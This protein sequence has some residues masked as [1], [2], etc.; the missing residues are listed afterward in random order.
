[1]NPE[2]TL[3]KM[4]QYGKQLEAVPYQIDRLCITF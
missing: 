3:G 1:V 2:E 4:I